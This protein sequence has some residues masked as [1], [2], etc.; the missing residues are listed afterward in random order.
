MRIKDEHLAQVWDRGF[1]VVEG[2]LDQVALSEAQESLW[3]KFPRPDAYFA[4][5]AAYPK[6]SRSQFAAQNHFPFAAPALDRL[7]VYPDLLD[8]AERMLGTTKIDAY[9]IELWAKYAGA[10][11]YD[12]I[13]HRDFGNH[14]LVVPRTDN[15]M[16]QMTTFILLSDVSEV[17]GPTKLVPLQKTQHVPLGRMMA[18]KGEFLADEVAATGPAGSILIYKTDVFH[19][20]SGMTGEHSSRFVLGVDFKQRGLPWQGKHAWPERA[21]QPGWTEA[22]V[23]MTPRQRDIFGWPEIGSDYWCEQT[24][25]DVALRYPGIDLSAYAGKDEM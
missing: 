9:K 20:A 12:Q 19:R 6:F 21:L 23:S 10:I 11:D 15:T 8:A 17:D 4:D 24:L 3:T 25:R 16:A 1:V 18:A 2:F 7:A 22:M 14:N 5:P 13:H